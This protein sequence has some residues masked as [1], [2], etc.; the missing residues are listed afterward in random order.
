MAKP[1]SGRRVTRL[2]AYVLHVKGR[3]CHLCWYDGATS[4]DHDPPRSVL[5]ARGVLD[6][7][8]PRYLFPA[9]LSCNV[10]RQARAITPEL[11]LELRR[12]R[13]R[14]VAIASASADLSPRFARRRTDLL[15]AGTPRETRAPRPFIAGN[16]GKNPNDA[17]TTRDEARP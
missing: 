13:E 12:R 7:D 15:S 1:W 9:H 4:A 10:R 3:V 11:R 16:V 17:G 14:D 2:V 5:I 8:D 6:P